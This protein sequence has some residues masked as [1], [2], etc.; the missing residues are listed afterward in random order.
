[1][2]TT[3]GARVL[4]DA[5]DAI[6]FTPGA[7]LPQDSYNLRAE[8]GP[9][10]FDTRQRFTGAASYSVKSLGFGPERLRSGWQLGLIVTAQTGR[11]IPIEDSYDNSGRYNHYNQRPDVV[12][13][14]NPILPHWNANTG[15]LNPNAFAQPADGTFGNLG[16]NSIFGPKFVNTDFSV[17]KTTKVTDW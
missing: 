10:T 11:P 5:S 7:T 12:P 1:M 15:Y 3:H 9:S 6:E 4:D 14:V 16:R 8:R 2:P 13:G 17:E